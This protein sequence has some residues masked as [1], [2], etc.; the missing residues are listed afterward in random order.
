VSLIAS[1]AD[2]QVIETLRKNGVKPGD[3]F[4]MPVGGRIDESAGDPV[5]ITG[6]VKTV[7]NGLG[8]GGAAKSQLWV[9]VEFGDGN[10]LLISPYLYQN[11]E[12]EAF[13]EIGINADDYEVI[14]IKSRV[15][16]RRGYYD[17]GYAKT[18]LLV[19]PDH[20]FVGTVR[21]EALN[22]QILDLQKFYPYGKDVTYP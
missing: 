5:S 8:W 1:V 17:S 6:T 19:E 12:P 3:A 18:I 21:L 2:E 11:T 22:Y 14:A 4:D 10:L 9:S 13:L 20:P 7:S 15:H 16:F